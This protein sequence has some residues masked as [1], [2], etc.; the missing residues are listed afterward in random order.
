[1]RLID[2]IKPMIEN[3]PNGSYTI[4]L[5]IDA[6]KRPGAV[7]ISHQVREVTVTPIKRKRGKA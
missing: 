6:K 4:Q 5:T 3:A 7:E 1:M 2:L